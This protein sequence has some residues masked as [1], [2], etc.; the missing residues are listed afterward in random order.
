LVPS[1]HLTRPIATMSVHAGRKGSNHWLFAK[2]EGSSS[3]VTGAIRWKCAII[4]RSKG[5]DS[6]ENGGFVMTGAPAMSSDVRSSASARWRVTQ[7]DATQAE[8]FQMSDQ[9]A[10]TRHARQI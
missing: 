8:R 5:C 7:M 6:R 3:Q 2:S 9:V 10:F 4:R 1:I